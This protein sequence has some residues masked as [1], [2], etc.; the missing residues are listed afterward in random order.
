M[1]DP[2]VTEASTLG[3]LLVAAAERSPDQIAIAF[4]ERRH[5]YDELVA[6]AV[7]RARSLRGLGIG[8][9]D[10]VGIL[11]PNAVEYAEILFGVAFL[12]AVSVPMNARYKET[13]L[14]FVIENADLDILLTTDLV[15]EHVDFVDLLGRSLPGIADAGDR[16]RLELA[17]APRL[18]SV[19]VMGTSHPDG[20]LSQNDFESVAVGAT[21][22]E[23][24][25]LRSRVASR[26][27]CI[28]MY[29]S[30]TTAHPKGC[31]LTH[32]AL[33]RSAKAMSRSRFLLTR[34]D[35]FWDP[36]PMFHM[37]AILPMTAVVDAGA[38]FLSLTHVEPGAGID[39]IV[40]EQPTVLFPSFPTLTAALVHH[41]RWPEVDVSAIRIVN[42]VGAPEM[43]REFQA[44]YPGAVQV[45]AYGL[46]E[47][48]GIVS[49]NDLTDSLEQRLTTCGK[50]FPG[51][52]IRVVD[53]ATNEPVVTGVRGEIT[54]RG[55]CLFEGYYRDPL[56][57]AKAMDADGWLHTGD[58]GSLDEDGRISYHGRLKDMLKVGGENVAALEIESFL[59]TH[60]S[61]KLV[62][63]VAAPDA[64]Y[65]EVPAAFVEVRDGAAVTADELI[66]FCNGKIAGFKIPRYVRF[67]TEWPISATKIQKY[68]LRDRIAAELASSS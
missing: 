37:S 27:V 64:R 45:S 54:V 13:E 15:A 32:E 12:G 10:H 56:S 43:L 58:F 21:A 50:P 4:P 53:P 63:V 41:P 17:A 16:F 30:G 60:P 44:A 59:S 1:P 65:D 31:Q 14:E 55:Y 20:M 11:M 35:R 40:A 3:D 26:N 47:A 51:I 42:N 19:V 6:K 8:P 24:H 2:P 5:T 62:Q 9:G 46:T 49:F 18:R 52:E 22:D 61:V 33:V 67:V 36:L 28:M 23:V 57:T 39:Q 34:S 7:W 66:E 38:T 68:R 25:D 29:T 48:A